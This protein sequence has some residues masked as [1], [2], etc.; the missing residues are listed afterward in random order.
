MGGDFTTVD[1]QPRSNIAALDAG[2][3]SL[4]SWDPGANG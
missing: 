3:G 2:D 4:R 1:G